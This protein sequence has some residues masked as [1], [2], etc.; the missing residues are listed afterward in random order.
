LFDQSFGSDPISYLP[1]LFWWRPATHLQL[2]STAFFPTPCWPYLYLDILSPTLTRFYSG[3][4]ISR[5]CLTNPPTGPSSVT[6]LSF[7]KRLESSVYIDSCI[8]LL[9]CVRRNPH[10]KYWRFSTMSFFRR[11]AQVR[12]TISWPVESLRDHAPPT[13]HGTSSPSPT[14]NHSSR[15]SDVSTAPTSSDGT[16]LSPSLASFDFQFSA[17]DHSCELESED[18]F[19]QLQEE[20]NISDDLPDK[21]TLSEA[22]DIPIYDSEGNAR[23]F[24]SLYSG[25]LAIGEQQLVIFVRHFY[26]GVSLIHTFLPVGAILTSTSNRPAKPISAPSQ[27]Q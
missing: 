11:K 14:S 6:T 16:N 4:Q 2:P 8:L 17:V 1:S 21:E 7:L 20:I 24:R 10:R 9:S 15:P 12:P 5:F 26:C 25:D 18:N 23:S 13:S 3:D 19:A 27:K 22:G